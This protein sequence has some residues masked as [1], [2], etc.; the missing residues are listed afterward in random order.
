MLRRT[1]L[2]APIAAPMIIPASAI[3]AGG[4]PP[5]S[6]R[7]TLGGLGIGSRGTRVLQ[8][9]L[10][11]AD[12][13]FLAICDVRNERRE[14]VKSMADKVYGNNDCSMYSDQEELWAR[15]DIDA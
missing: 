2:K 12:V 14:A 4:T 6:D 9:F 3:G 1:L 13:R 5:P 15:K 11:Q 8:S 10:E 7:V